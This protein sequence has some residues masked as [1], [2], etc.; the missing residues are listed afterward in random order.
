MLLYLYIYIH[1]TVGGIASDSEHLA[2]KNVFH[3]TVVGAQK[4]FHFTVKGVS[5]HGKKCFV[6]R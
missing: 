4:V 5:F 1:I 3:F 2:A 6:S